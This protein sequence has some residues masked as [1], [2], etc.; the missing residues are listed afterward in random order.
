MTLWKLSVIV[1][2]HGS[3]K[4]ELLILGNYVST[5]KTTN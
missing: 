2:T 3:H 1:E 5:G 4:T